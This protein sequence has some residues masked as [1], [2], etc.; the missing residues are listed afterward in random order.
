MSTG[1]II[2]DNKIYIG[3]F[4]AK[5]GIGLAKWILQF[6]TDIKVIFPDS[7]RS[8]IKSEIDEMSEYYSE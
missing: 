5:S 2:K 6:G 4:I 3:I 8:I 7:L 1:D